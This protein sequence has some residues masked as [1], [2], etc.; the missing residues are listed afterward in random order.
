VASSESQLLRLLP[1]RLRLPQ[2]RRWLRLAVLK[3]SGGKSAAGWLP[4]WQR[5]RAV[6]ADQGGWM[7]AV[8]ER[9]CD[10]CV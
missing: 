2:R 6:A 4:G 8:L 5:L 7:L 1:L 3:R 9:H 10:T